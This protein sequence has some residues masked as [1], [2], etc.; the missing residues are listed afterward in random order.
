MTKDKINLALLWP[1]HDGK[2]TSV[3][4]LVLGLDKERFN[5]IF[6]YLSGYGIEENL[7]E[8][9]GYKVFYLSNIELIN[10][11]RFS[12]LFKLIRIIRDHKIDILHCHVHKPTFYGILAA[13]FAGTPVVLS[14]V[15]GLG[16]SGNFRRKLANFL[17]SRKLTRIISVANGV[18]EDVLRNNWLLPAEKVSVLENSVDYGRFVNVSITKAEARQMLGL[19]ADA[20]V[21]GTVGRL[22]PTKGLPYLIEAFSRAKEEIPSARLVLLGNG[23]SRAKL[24]Q[25]ASTTSCRDSIHFL[26]HRDNIEQLYRA[27]DTFVLSSV[28]EGMPRAILEAMAAGVPCIATQVGGIPEIINSREVGLLVPS[29]DPEALARAMIDLAQAPTEQIE[30]LT[31][32]ASDRIG[33]FYSHKVVGE[34]LNNLYE[35]EFEARVQC[36]KQA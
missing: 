1:E 18:K 2:V 31:E 17:L 32:K 10:A 34:K 14:H 28:A 20:F 24:E 11:F 26:G 15:H 25:Q 3:N 9:E 29:K 19:P 21:F 33:R 27:M 13:R 6:I 7:I 4:D 30:E 12:I 22:A 5:V 23:P 35:N 8:E 16:R 36:P